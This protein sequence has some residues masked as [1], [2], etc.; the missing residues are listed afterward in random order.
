[1]MAG[2]GDELLQISGRI[3]SMPGMSVELAEELMKLD[4]LAHSLKSAR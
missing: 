1:M 4:A 2:A 3:A